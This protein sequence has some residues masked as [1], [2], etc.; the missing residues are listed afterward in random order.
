MVLPLPLPPGERV[1]GFGGGLV[2]S[3]LEDGRG[4]LAGWMLQAERPSALRH[5]AWHVLCHQRG[6]GG[7]LFSQSWGE[8]SLVVPAEY[9]YRSLGRERCWS[10][11]ALQPLPSVWLLLRG[12]QE[13]ALNLFF[14]DVLFSTALN[15]TKSGPGKLKVPFHF[16]FQL[17]MKIILRIAGGA[18]R[19]QLEDGD[20][21]IT[22]AE[23]WKSCNA[24]PAS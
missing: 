2:D 21:G 5:A 7:S 20:M 15:G 8:S 22:T 1:L 18:R 4:G 9:L 17:R 10:G 24:L 14:G 23:G 11:F 19:E 16:S 6:L 12:S 13:A 3:S